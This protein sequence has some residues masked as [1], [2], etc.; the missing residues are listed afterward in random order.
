[1][2]EIVAHVKP[3]TFEAFMECRRRVQEADLQRK[4]DKQME[5]YKTRLEK[6]MQDSI[7]PPRRYIIDK[8]LNLHC[9]RCEKVF[10]DFDGCLALTCQA[11]GCDCGFCAVCLQD[12][13][14]DAHAHVRSCPYANS[15]G[16]AYL[17]EGDI[18]PA[19]NAWRAD[20]L[21]KFLAPLSADLAQR[22][23]SSLKRE[24][25]DVGLDAQTF[26]D[27]LSS[28]VCQ[29][30]GA[31]KLMCDVQTVR[32]RDTDLFAMRMGRTCLWI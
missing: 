31:T 30:H 19:Q 27:G 2:Q 18:K 29:R 23:L 32:M 7:N 13:G 8:I 21:R 16:G 22:V 14:T 24:L 10:L 6:E 26:L 25:A 15:G 3:A 20:Q 17:A 11:P 5:E 4:L 9:P 28:E 1:M 12:C